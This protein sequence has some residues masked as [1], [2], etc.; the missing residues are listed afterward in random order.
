[1]AAYLVLMFCEGSQ[2]PGCRA[3]GPHGHWSSAPCC[4]PNAGGFGYFQTRWRLWPG[5]PRLDQDL[6]QAVG[7]TPVPAPSPVQGTPERRPGLAPE[8]PAPP[9]PPAKPLAPMQER[10]SESKPEASPR[11]PRSAPVP[12]GEPRPV[13]AKPVEA[14]PAEAPVVPPEGSAAKEKAK[15]ELPRPPKPGSPKAPAVSPS[16]PAPVPPPD[17]KGNPKAASEE[18]PLPWVSQSGAAL[19]N[20]PRWAAAASHAAGGIAGALSHVE[21]W[22]PQDRPAAGTSLQSGPT[23]R[24]PAPTYRQDNLVES[25]TPGV[26]DSIRQ[27]AHL[28]PAGGRALPALE[29]FCPVELVQNERWVAGDA[30]YTA[31]YRGRVYFFAGAAQQQEF[32]AN[33]ER[34]VPCHSGIDPV[35][36]LEGRPTPGQTDYCAVYDGRLYMFS[37]SQTLAEFRQNPRRYASLLPQASR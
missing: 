29:G 23:P 2:P 5:E 28:A 9:M 34:Y 27:A 22:V 10:V 26:A 1:M 16:L 19:A 13:G 11:K 25:A 21:L 6:P 33:P 24:S 4:A 32:L 12:A 35:T 15:P 8:L 31:E 14:K 36:L 7:R 3:E 20:Q 37:S 17:A 30:R 18:P